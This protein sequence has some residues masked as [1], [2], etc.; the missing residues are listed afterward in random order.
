MLTE[1][2][3]GTNIGVGLGVL[4]EL[5][6]RVMIDSHLALPGLLLFGLS[7]CV[8][9][10]GC[11]QYARAKGHS[12]WFGAFGIFSLIGLLVLFFLPDRHKAII[13]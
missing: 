10:W 2:K 4:G 8:F 7:L 13:T 9:V 6:G 12:G 1:Y 5:L 11:G 3:R